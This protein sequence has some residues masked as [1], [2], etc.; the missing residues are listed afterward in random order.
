VH[1]YIYIY[2]CVHIFRILSFAIKQVLKLVIHMCQRALISVGFIILCSTK[3][4]G[5]GLS[6]TGRAI[7]KDATIET[8]VGTFSIESRNEVYTKMTIL[9]HFTSFY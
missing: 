9:H 6:S 8:F 5:E 2:V 1:V 3:D 7:G 4:H